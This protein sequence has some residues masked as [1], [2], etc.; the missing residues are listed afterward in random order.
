MSR[1]RDPRAPRGFLHFPAGLHVDGEDFTQRRRLVPLA[2]YNAA[3]GRKPDD[4]RGYKWPPVGPGVYL[5]A[6]GRDDRYGRGRYHAY[7]V[8]ERSRRGERKTE[9]QAAARAIRAVMEDV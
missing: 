7:A 6:G 9:R 2:E 3:C 5:R 8:L 4:P 1:S